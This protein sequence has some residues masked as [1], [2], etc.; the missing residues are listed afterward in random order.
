VARTEAASARTEASSAREQV[1]SQAEVMQQ[2]QLELGHVTSERDQLR[3]QVAEAA[4]RVLELALPSKLI[5]RGSE[6]NV[7]KVSIRDGKSSINLASQGHCA[8]VF[9]GI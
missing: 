6:S 1:A 7:N 9:I 2:R 4:S 5:Q 3:G 8:G